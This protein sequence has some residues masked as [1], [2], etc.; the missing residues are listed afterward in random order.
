MI[1]YFLG[2]IYLLDN[3]VVH[4]G[5]TVA[6]GA[7]EVS[8]PL[9]HLLQLV[10]R[11]LHRHR[12]AVG[13]VFDLSALH[14]VHQHPQLRRIADPAALD[15]VSYTHLDVYKRQAWEI[16]RS[17]AAVRW[18]TP[19]SCRSRDRV[20]ENSVVEAIVLSPSELNT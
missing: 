18:E 20:R 13:A 8:R 12:A 10:L 6:H 5:N 11:Q 19:R 3:A 9:E 2:S 15:A 17:P 4:Y 1:V 16:P 7:F 14:P